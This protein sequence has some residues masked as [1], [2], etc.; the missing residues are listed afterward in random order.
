MLKSKH[1]L[2]LIKLLSCKDQKTPVSS[3]KEGEDL[4]ILWTGGKVAL[5]IIGKVHLGISSY[6]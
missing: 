6:D 1:L 3:V 4:A 5:I 2:F